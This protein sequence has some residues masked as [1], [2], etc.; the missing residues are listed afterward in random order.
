MIHLKA[1]FTV[2][3]MFFPMMAQALVPPRF[4]WKSLAGANAVPVI[5]QNLSGNA[6]PIDPAHVVSANTNFEAH[7]NVVG[8]AKMLPVLGRT[9]TV[10]LLQPM[11]RISSNATVAGLTTF[12]DA[13]GYGDPMIEIGMNIIGPKAIK[14]IPDIL[15][16]EPKFSLDLIMDV[17]APLGEYDSDQALN[18]GQNRWYGRVGAP[19]VWQIGAWVPGRRTTFELLPSVWLFGDNNNYVNGKTLE[20]DP[21]YQWEAHV[22]RD[23]TENFW[24]SIDGTQMTGGKSHVNGVAAGESLNNLGVGLTLGYQLNDN[25]SLTTAYMSTINDSSPTDLKMDGVTFSFTYG[26]H[27]IVEGQKRL[28]TGH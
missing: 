6:N 12:E 1:G 22:T 7:I 18:L 23:F 11:G 26:W 2:M 19:I 28:I 4:Y 16:Y 9:A 10:A 3:L 5:S 20:T 13:S 17:A 27:K 14:N 15:R 25:L 8:F 21:M 24:F